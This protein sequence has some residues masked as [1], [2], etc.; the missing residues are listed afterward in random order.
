MPRKPT[1]KVLMSC[2][3]VTLKNGDIYICERECQYNPEIK[4]TKRISNNF[5]AKVPK[6]TSKVSSWVKRIPRTYPLP[7]ANK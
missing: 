1:D 4:K 2:A 6:G 3:K 7:E 5:V